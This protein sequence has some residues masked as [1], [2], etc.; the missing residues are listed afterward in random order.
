[1]TQHNRVFQVMLA[2]GLNIHDPAQWAQIPASPD[3]PSA[4]SAH[5]IGAPAGGRGKPAKSRR[6]GPAKGPTH[7]AL[8][9]VV[10][11][12]STTPGS[13]SG[14]VCVPSV[15]ANSV[16]T[17]VRVHSTVAATVSGS[18]GAAV[19][20][21][22]V[23]ADLAAHNNSLDSDAEMPPHPR[24]GRWVVESSDE[25]TERDLEAT[26]RGSF[27]SAGLPVSVDLAAQD[28]SLDDSEPEVLP[29]RRAAPRRSRVVL[30][31][32]DEDG[33]AQQV[34]TTVA[35]STF[36]LLPA[37][38]AAVDDVVAADMSLVLS[39]ETS[40]VEMPYASDD[41]TDEGGY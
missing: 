15:P 13:R 16:A 20:P 28:M 6:R 25:E 22:P 36:Q 1:M 21:C 7:N 34:A 12:A 38:I 33:S 8:V 14:V 29:S 31:S 26:V 30:S 9:P 41:S 40:R 23:R 18:V 32:D 5:S 24:P 35:E 37:S 39:G 11:P 27:G 3:V 2:S 17:V 4:W 19:P 10:A